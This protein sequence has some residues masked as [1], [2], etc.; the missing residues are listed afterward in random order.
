MQN[1]TRR[2]ALAAI[3]DCGMGL[4]VP[5]IAETVVAPRLADPMAEYAVLR[6]QYFEEQDGFKADEVGEVWIPLFYE[7]VEFRCET[8]ADAIAKARFMV[9]AFDNHEMHIFED[10]GLTALRTIAAIPHT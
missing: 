7:I 6:D 2:I 5:A 8:V 4:A 9:A 10:D 1:I 3:S